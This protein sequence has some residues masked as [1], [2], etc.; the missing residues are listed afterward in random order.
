MYKKP[1]LHKKD[2]LKITKSNN[3]N[4]EEDLQ[5][6]GTDIPENSGTHGSLSYA[7]GHT[8][9]HSLNRTPPS[10]TRIPIVEESFVNVLP[11][12]TSSIKRKR[13]TGT[14]IEGANCS[15]TSQNTSRGGK[16][17]YKRNNSESDSSATEFSENE[18]ADDISFV[19]N[20][21][22]VNLATIL[23]ECVKEVETVRMTSSNLKGGYVKKLK[24]AEGRIKKVC[25]ELHG[26][27]SKSHECKKSA[28][29]LKQNLKLTKQVKHLE[30]RLQF[31]EAQL[32]KQLPTAETDST[33]ALT[34]SHNIP[35][36]NN[37]LSNINDN[38]E[39]TLA[40][41]RKE[42][43]TLLAEKTQCPYP[44][45]ISASSS[46]H[47]APSTTSR[48]PLNVAS[49]PVN[50]PAPHTPESWATITKRN[51]KKNQNQQISGA[52][53]LPTSCPPPSSSRPAPDP[54][55]TASRPKVPVKKP[56]SVDIVYLSETNNGKL[57]LPEILRKAKEKIDLKEL[58]IETIKPRTSINGGL[59]LE[60]PKQKGNNAATK[61]AEKISELFDSE[62]V[63]VR[64]PTKFK[65]FLITNLDF[66]TTKS[67]LLDALALISGE[68]EKIILGPIRANKKGTATVWC[69]C[70]ETLAYK[71]L[72]K[73]VARIGWSTARFLPLENRPSQCYKC[74]AYGHVRGRCTSDIDMAGWCYKCGQDG[75]PSNECK[76][77]NPTCK[78]CERNK[79]DSKHRMGSITCASYIN[80][81]KSAQKPQ[82]S[83]TNPSNVPGKTN[84]GL[85]G[86]EKKKKN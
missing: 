24:E 53:Y 25:S 71:F 64:C 72:S 42:I 10:G 60:I 66:A 36:L 29:L 77:D 78:L 6:I 63:L 62:D 80:F 3:N 79:Y 54:N 59:I 4:I 41:F 45:S 23:L 68:N 16:K 44:V 34:S 9:K 52:S 17:S 27:Q 74:W 20:E 26:E 14:E 37:M 15:K 19:Y 21:S 39:T 28:D 67:E 40:D 83:S 57:K 2:T 43:V 75:H 35:T 30:A 56:R 8:P 13:D 76:K 12:T 84:A 33:S 58:G 70:S 32:A 85:E 82:T 49:A 50:I 1:D 69:K 48:K 51:K 65:E 5:S 55:P 46:S 7:A 61:L 18:K 86:P 73:Q 47:Q 22:N 11:V 38:I 81:K 31:V